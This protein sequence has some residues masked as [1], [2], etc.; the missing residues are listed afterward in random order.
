ML[1]VGSQ[2]RL[3]LTSFKFED[4]TLAL[5][6]VIVSLYNINRLEVT[7]VVNWCYINKIV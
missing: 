4:L 1:G 6:S 3:V 2:S 5:C 7:S